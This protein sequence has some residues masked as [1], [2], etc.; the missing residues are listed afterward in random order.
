MKTLFIVISSILAIV[1]ILPYIRDVYRK[2]TKP[3]IV[4]WLTW[5]LLTAIACAASFSDG[6]YATGIL[7][8]LAS[9]ET[10]SV[11]ILG[12]RYGDRQFGTFDIGCQV[13]A[14]IGLI[15]WL[16]FNSPS[17]A[18]I[19]T[20]IIDVIASLPTLRHAWQKP[21]EETAI[22]FLLGA[23][24]AFFTLMASNS[25]A[26]TAVVFPAYL[27]IMNSLISGVIYLRQHAMKKPA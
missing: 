9:V 12:L 14:I 19:A 17:I 11:V 25:L 4:S 3:R 10:M 27:V 24:A 8:F 13:A 23:I 15:L 26:I 20:V 18:I 16:I 1:N 6:Q 7:L 22:T 5:S 21:F 2:K